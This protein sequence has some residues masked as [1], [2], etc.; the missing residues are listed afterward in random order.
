MK[1]DFTYR[2]KLD[3]L[4]GGRGEGGGWQLSGGAFFQETI[5]LWAFLLGVFF[6]KP[7]KCSTNVKSF[8]IYVISNKHIKFLYSSIDYQLLPYTPACGY[9]LHALA[10]YLHPTFAVPFQSE[11]HL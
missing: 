1:V 7:K 3:T 11:V 9:K 10:V 6:L 8:T 5:F 2:Q 4:G